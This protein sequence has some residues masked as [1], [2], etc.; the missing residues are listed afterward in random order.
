M[1]TR[2]HCVTKQAEPSDCVYIRRS[3]LQDERRG[4]EGLKVQVFPHIL[5]G[6]RW[7]SGSSSAILGFIFLKS[8]QRWRYCGVKQPGAHTHAHTHTGGEE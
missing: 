6:R 4:G 7:V 1:E 8:E 3:V 5:P 2:P